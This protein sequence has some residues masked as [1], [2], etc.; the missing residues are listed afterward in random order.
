[1]CHSAY[2]L[3]TVGGV[4]MGWAIMATSHVEAWLY[5]P[6][7]TRIV[8]GHAHSGWSTVWA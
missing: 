6:S 8:R 4:G 5:F 2:P 1:M 7:D 3:S